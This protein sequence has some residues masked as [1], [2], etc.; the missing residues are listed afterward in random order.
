MWGNTGMASTRNFIFRA[1]DRYRGGSVGRAIGSEADAAD[2]QNFVDHVL[3]KETRLSSRY[4]SFTQEVKIAQRFTSATDLR[5][6]TKASMDV[7]QKLEE[8]GIIRMWDADLV[9]TSLRDGPRKLAKQAADVR[10][11]MKR[12]CEILIEGQIPEGV[13]E[14][15]N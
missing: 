1:D 3:R 11:A 5:Y 10:T 14:P 2:I 4:T 12:N 9:F 8:D 7:L 13:L 15:T 6:V